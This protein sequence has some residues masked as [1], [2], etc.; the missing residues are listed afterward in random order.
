MLKL[1]VNE[2][3]KMLKR[4][5]TIIATIIVVLACV[6]LQLILKYTFNNLYSDE[7]YDSRSSMTVEAYEESIQQRIEDGDVLHSTKRQLEF[8]QA[9]KKVGIKEMDHPCVSEVEEVI[10]S[11]SYHGMP[12]EEKDVPQVLELI[13]YECTDFTHFL[14]IASE[15]SDMEYTKAAL[16]NAIT[17]PY[18]YL[19]DKGVKDVDDERVQKVYDIVN[20]QNQIES[21]DDNSAD[22]IEMIKNYKVT[23]YALDNN[24]GY[25]IDDNTSLSMYSGEKQETLW[26]VL[27]N[28]SSIFAILSICMLVLAGQI[29]AKEFSEGTIKFLLINPVKRGKIITSKYLTLVS[30]SFILMVVT[31]VINI[32]LAVIFNGGHNLGCQYVTYSLSKEKVVAYAAILYYAK[33][34]LLSFVQVIVYETM[35]FALSSLLRSTAAAVGAG[36]ACM[37]GG[38]IV[39]SIMMAFHIDWG[40]YLIFSNVDLQAVMNQT[41]GYIGHTMTFAVGVIVVHMIVFLLTAYDGFV[42]RE[43]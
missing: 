9:L 7:D 2:Y 14:E 15:Q 29:V 24:L 33:T 17:N 18:K 34:Y 30:M 22:T 25:Y 43:V 1:I 16:N 4:K 27:L 28:S 35:A 40:R 8:V 13:S 21:Y 39:T 20:L 42:R 23:K 37:L 6:G 19:L 36:I 10:L 5:S 31:F 26:M 11:G 3:I 12:V 38:S 41:T 32:V